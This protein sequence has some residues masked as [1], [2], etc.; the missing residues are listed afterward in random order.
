MQE[1]ENEKVKKVLR[2]LNKTYPHL[3]H[4][5]KFSNPL[6]LLVATILSAQVPDDRVNAVTS[7]LFKKYKTA[8]DFANADQQALINAIKTISF[9]GNKGRNIKATCKVLVEKYKGQVPKTLDE[10]TALPGIARKSANAIL[11]NAFGIVE[12]VIVDTHCLRLSHRLG[13]TDL[14][15]NAVKAERQLMKLLPKSAWKTFPWLMKEH[16]RHIC[17]VML[18]S[19]NHDFLDP[20]VFNPVLVEARNGA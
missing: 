16:G 10:L 6:Q 20:A 17:I 5:L 15:K 4:Y 2:I 1:K 19:V 9:A 12:G 3:K 13:W 18:A 8:K 14:P 11:Q 7:E